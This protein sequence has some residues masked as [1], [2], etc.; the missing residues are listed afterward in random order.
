MLQRSS[1]E[2][3]SM[4]EAPWQSRANVPP[5]LRPEVMIGAASPLWGYFTGAALAGIGWWWMIRWAQRPAAFETM[6]D[7]ALEPAAQL[8]AEAV[9]GAVA[10]ALVTDA[11]PVLPVGGE[12]APF[13]AATL[14]AELISEPELAQA[15]AP[16]PEPAA[17]PE[18]AETPAPE[19]ELA[20]ALKPASAARSRKPREGEPKPH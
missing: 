9:D 3:I 6:I 2:E 11:T 19:P 8:V 20:K 1:M 10:E 4:S 13:G 12:A 14:E 16:E 17:A 7:A 18:L 15:L 5:L